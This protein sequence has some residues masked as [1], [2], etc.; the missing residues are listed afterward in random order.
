MPATRSARRPRRS[1]SPT[2]S[3]LR[4][5]GPGRTATSPATRRCRSA[6][7]PPRSCRSCRCS[8]A[9]IRSR[10]RARSSRSSPATRTSACA[11]SRRRT[12]SPPR[13]PP[14]VLRSAARSASPPPPALESSSR[15]RRS[16]SRSCS[17]SR[18]D[19]FD[20]AIEACRIALKYR[21]PVYLLSDAYLA[22]GSEPW[23]LP[24]VDSLPD[25]SVEFATKPN[26]GDAFLPH[27]RDD[28]TLAR[29][30]AVPGTPGP[31]HR[32]GGVEKE[33]RTG[34]V[35]YD[36]DNHDLMTRLRA[37]KIAGIDVPDLEVDDPDGDSSVLVL[38][39]G[40]TY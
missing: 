13:G 6:S 29:P 9:R 2:R 17:S 3:S 8:S 16:A 19:C 23:L 7:S 22:N 20:A 5:S 35:S 36:P 11:R 1:R 24:S 18:S 34:N 26:D 14:S 31:E 21:T 30:W 10:R 40:G 37:Q 32:I 4:S 25:I 33:D 12:R 28:E 39:W 38:G 27:L 15:R